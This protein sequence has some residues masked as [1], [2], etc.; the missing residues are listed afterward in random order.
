MVHRLVDAAEADAASTG[1]VVTTT[2]ADRLAQTLDAAL[3]DPERPDC[4]EPDDSPA[5]YAMSV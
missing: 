3:V 4:C 1:R 5:H 2:V